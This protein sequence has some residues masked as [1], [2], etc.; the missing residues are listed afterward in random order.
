M[1]LAHIVLAG[2]LLQPAWTAAQVTPPSQQRPIKSPTGQTVY[3]AP[4]DVHVLAPGQYT[5]P[6]AYQYSINGRQPQQYYQEDPAD[7]VFRAAYA[8]FSRQEYRQAAE[9]FSSLRSRFTTSRYY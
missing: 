9:R 3:W 7:S 8:Y 4:A 2:A 6:Q 1:R 5:T